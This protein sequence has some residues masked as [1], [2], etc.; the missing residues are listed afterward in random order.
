M[1]LLR[2]LIMN[3]LL[4]YSLS[5]KFR[6]NDLSYVYDTFENFFINRSSYITK[7][8]KNFIGLSD[9]KN[10]RD[11]NIMRTDYFQT[12]LIEFFY[13][14]DLKNLECFPLENKTFEFRGLNQC[15]NQSY[16]HYFLVKNKY[17]GM[18]LKATSF[19]NDEIL[20]SNIG[21]F[22]NV[23]NS[24]ENI[25][26]NTPFFS[27][28]NVSK[29]SDYITKRGCNIENQS[30][31]QKYFF[32][33]YLEKILFFPSNLTKCQALNLALYENQ[34]FD[35]NIQTISSIAYFMN[36]VSLILFSF[37]IHF[38]REIPYGFK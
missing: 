20:N 38:T 1:F 29:N 4:V 35:G 21:F 34:M 30:I 7:D 23:Y 15:L 31:Y 28:L 27:A 33:A 19:E 9:L 10:M 16:Y 24:K 17:M 12:R 26:E 18:T 37:S 6:M 11:P 3:F 25:K 2:N 22:S 8:S 5:L 36:P 13:N 14:S 32:D